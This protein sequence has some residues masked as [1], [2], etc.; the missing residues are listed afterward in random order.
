M[1][2]LLIPTITGLVA[3]VT[4]AGLPKQYAPLLAVVLGIVFALT[5]ELHLVIGISSGL[6]SVGLWEAG[7]FTHK[8][9]KND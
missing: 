6:A 1:E 7:K 5:N 9:M 2:T 3:V 4:Q 8:I